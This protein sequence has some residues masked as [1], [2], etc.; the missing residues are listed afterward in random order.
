MIITRITSG[1]GNQLFQYAIGRSLALRYNTSLYFDLSYYLQTYE[2]DTV[3][4]FK[5]DR[6]S[7][8]YQVLNTSPYLYVSKFTK[9]LPNRSLK[10]VFAFVQEQQFHYDP[11]VNQTKAQFVTL[12]GFW[13]SERYF[14][15]YAD[16]IRQELT[17]RRTPGPAF[18][19]YQARIGQTETPISLHIRRGDYVNHPEFS[20]S[21][22]FVGLDYYQRATA[23][24]LEQHPNG[25][26]FV[27]SDDPA[28][29]QENLNLTTA[30]TFVTNTGSDA[31][32]DDLQLMSQCH[33]HIIAN[34]S[35]SWWGAWLSSN[36]QKTVLAPQAWFRNKPDWNTADLI[37][38][39][40]IRT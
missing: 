23:K 18:G 25:H 6:F 16:I 22:G 35:F 1:L 29:V 24:M 34:S 14:A 33:H 17:F 27:F 2:T 7:I 31:D 26:F 39:R 4:L 15:G 20:Q 28:W 12:D 21:F 5:L 13:Q 11:R 19:A 37:P 3:R 36:P 9:L 40:W 38:S 8:D 32:V 30:H 10:P